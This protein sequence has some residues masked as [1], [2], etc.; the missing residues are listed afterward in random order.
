MKSRFTLTII[1]ALAL[2]LS[3]ALA[4]AV[5]GGDKTQSFPPG[6]CHQNARLCLQQMNAQISKLRA[7]VRHLKPGV[8]VAFNPQPDPPGDPDPLYRQANEAYRNLLAEFADLSDNAEIAGLDSAP[9]RT[10]LSD[11]QAKLRSLASLPAGDNRAAANQ[12]LNALSAS[13]QRLS[14]ET[15]RGHHK[16]GDGAN[17]GTTTPK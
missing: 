4:V 6:P 12:T 3:L 5:Q 10:T 14:R 15:K 16:K 9:S 2:S 1:P 11:A 7:Y 17:T 13:V 8:A